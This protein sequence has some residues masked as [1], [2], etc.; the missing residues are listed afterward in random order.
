MADEK[1]VVDQ[2]GPPQG[3]STAPQ[4]FDNAIPSSI[5]E[6]IEKYHA[7]PADET[8]KK[9][10][11]ETL[12]KAKADT[13]AKAEF[14]KK[15]AEELAKAVPPDYKNLKLPDGTKLKGK[16]LESVVEFAKSAK[17]P[18]DTAQA[19]L[20]RDNDVVNSYVEGLGEDFKKY[21]E[22]GRATLQK[23]WGEKYK[24]NVG[25]AN[26]VVEF[27]EKQIP[28]IKAEID[29]LGLNDSVKANEFFLR[30]YQDLKMGNDKFEFSGNK[31][32][33]K[34]DAHGKPSEGDLAKMFPASLG[35][36]K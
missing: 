1:S 36:A 14:A 13:L 21:S 26:K 27:Y 2:K 32:T 34:T 24:E 30:V 29:R 11:E 9:S 31:D 22:E 15:Q 4:T 20:S 35:A 7:N 6:T 10:F 19:I 17:L 8:L 3:D 23:N 33:T 28:G 16:H 12:G 5:L 18:L 25:N